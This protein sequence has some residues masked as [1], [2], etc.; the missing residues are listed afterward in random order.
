[1]AN[2]EIENYVEDEFKL[3][4]SVL[5]RFVQIFQE[6]MLTGIDVSDIMRM[7]RLKRSSSDANVLVLTSAYEEMIKE[8]H[9]KMVT[10][11][12]LLKRG[13]SNQTLVLGLVKDEEESN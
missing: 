6:A 10:H 8:H 4:D 5:H 1:M 11:A 3:A 7:I 9:Q 12:E 2:P 13:S